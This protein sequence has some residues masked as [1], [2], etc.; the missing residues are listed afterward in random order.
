MSENTL[1]RRNLLKSVAL[2]A[3]LGSLSTVDAQHVHHH[4]EQTKQAAG[5]AYK[6]ALFN[7]HEFK[8]M[9]LLSDLIIP[10]ENGEVGGKGAGSAEFIDLLAANNL[11]IRNHFLGGLAWLDHAMIR[12]TEKNFLE[13]SADQRTEM[14]DLIAYN[15]NAS[16]ELGPG[17]DFFN[18]ARRMV[19]DAYFTSPAGVKALGYKGNVGMME[20]QVPKEALTY[21]LQRSPFKDE[22]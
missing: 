7:D 17:I 18:W 11:T 6:P 10:P 16:P 13:A 3:G 4:V 12:R 22:A 19:V 15:K 20:F 14:L 8:T 1:D 5:G 2:V 21:A 9:Q